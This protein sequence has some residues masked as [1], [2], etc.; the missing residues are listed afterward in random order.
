MI[1]LYEF[2]DN[3]KMPIKKIMTYLSGGPYYALSNKG[4]IN[5]KRKL[6]VC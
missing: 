4:R 5:N 1:L 2:S 6:V 3:P